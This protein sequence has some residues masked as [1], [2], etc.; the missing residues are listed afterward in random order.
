VA[1]DINALAAD[2]EVGDQVV[3]QRGLGGVG[4]DR[5]AA[6]SLGGPQP[7]C[8]PVLAV[9]DGLAVAPALGA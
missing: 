9:G 8:H 1:A 4:L 7:G 6:C 5:D 3:P 2:V